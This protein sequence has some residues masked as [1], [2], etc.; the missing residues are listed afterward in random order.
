MGRDMTVETFRGAGIWRM[1]R[2]QTERVKRR[3]SDKSDFRRPKNINKLLDVGPK[4]HECLSLSR[5]CHGA[6]R[7]I[8][9]HA[10]AS[11]ANRRACLCGNLK[12]FRVGVVVSEGD[13]LLYSAGC[14]FL[15]HLQHE[16]LD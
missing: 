15:H 4:I 14:D 2:S 13:C 10:S 6:I 8:K 1:L 11:E 3:D 9:L 7:A 5:R 12:P 16:L